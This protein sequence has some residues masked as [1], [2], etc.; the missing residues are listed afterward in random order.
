MSNAAQRLSDRVERVEE[1]SAALLR[2]AETISATNTAWDL[3]QARRRLH[4]WA[5]R[6]AA[7]VRTLAHCS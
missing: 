2:S 4:E 6:Y 5:R 7:A 3:A 1:T